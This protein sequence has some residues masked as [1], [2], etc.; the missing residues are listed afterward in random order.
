MVNT[1]VKD[2]VLRTT[3]RRLDRQK[4]AA[5]KMGEKLLEDPDDFVA[6]S[7]LEYHRK[8]IRKLKAAKH[9]KSSES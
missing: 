9:A 6:E 3:N 7:S 1:M 2:R 5:R 8:Q 4:K